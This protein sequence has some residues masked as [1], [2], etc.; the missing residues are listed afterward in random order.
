MFEAQITRHIAAFIRQHLAVQPTA[1]ISVGITDKQQTLFSWSY[2]FANLEA[3]LPLT[4]AHLMQIGSIGKSFTSLALMQLFDED[5]FDPQTP[6]REFLPWLEFRNGGSAVTCHHLLTH[7]S[8]LIMGTDESI[9]SFGEAWALR[10]IPVL[11]PTGRF[12]Y[13][14][15]G[16]KILGLVLEKLTGKPY[17][18][19]IRE[20]VL[21]PLGMNFSEPTI[22]N[23]VYARHA[24]GYQPFPYDRTIA[25]PFKDKTRL[26]PAPWLE[27][28]T[29]DGCISSTPGDMAI[30]IRSLMNGFSP[31]IRADTFALMTTPHVAIMAEETPLH[32]GYG[33]DL[34]NEDGAGRIAHGGGMVGYTSYLLCQ[35][36][37]GIGVIVLMNGPGGSGPAAQ[38][39]LAAA[40]AAVTGEALP[41][42]PEPADYFSIP[43]EQGLAGEYHGRSRVIRIEKRGT[44]LGIAGVS[45]DLALRAPDMLHI[46]DPDWNEFFIR[47]RRKETGEIEALVHG[48]DVYYRDHFPAEPVA[49]PAEDWQAYPGEYTAFNPWY[50]GFRVVLR[51]NNLVLMLYFE[52]EEP[53]F[54]IGAGFFRVG[55]EESP[56]TLRF[57]LLHEGTAMRAVYSGAVYQRKM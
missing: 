1:G 7:T 54:E 41:E 28:D 29:A 35:P 19:V 24:G 44:G 45:P 53:L 34:E 25:R 4:P 13:S 43:D 27:T 55:S 46:D 18:E 39:V 47:M 9:T 56:E 5:R 49:A 22:T 21:D 48:G 15:T 17:G 42:I 11:P 3:Q 20:R 52:I 32:Y 40:L 31:L 8:G 38:F 36:D 16:Y 10:D 37:P 51:E 6:V 2:G 23:S 57:D 30:Y 12:H 26:S 50:P 14:N 33:L